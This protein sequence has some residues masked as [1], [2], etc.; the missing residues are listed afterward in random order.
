[1]SRDRVLSSARRIFAAKGYAATSLREIA[2]AS[3]IKTPSI[4]AH[5]ESKQALFETV[6]AAIAE[7]HTTYFARLAQDSLQLDPIERVKHLLEG[8]DR[9]YAD[10]PEAAEFSLRA[11]AE[12]QSSELPS[13]RQTFLD[14]ES[15]LANAFR[16]AYQEGR[17][18][19]Q[20]VGPDDPD[21]F[22]NLALLMMDGLF[23]QRAHYSPDLFQERFA[24]VWH[25]LVSL[26]SVGED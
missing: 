11:A 14:F 1:M 13:L 2:I 19:E 3:G 21:G 6:Y 22:V 25:H 8:V 18:R 24:I 9:F 12:E 7:E 15:S 17:S 16:A 23:L 4:Y 10:Q 5:F 26:I 20:I